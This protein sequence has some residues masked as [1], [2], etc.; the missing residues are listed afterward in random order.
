MLDAL[1]IAGRLAFIATTVTSRNIAR[2]LK[3]IAEKLNGK[4]ESDYDDD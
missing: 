4:R 3:R 1:N 2:R